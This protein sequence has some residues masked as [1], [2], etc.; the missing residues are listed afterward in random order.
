M[1][2]PTRTR[3]DPAAL[4]DPAFHA[5]GDPH[6]VWRWMRAHSPV[7]HHAP[8]ELPAFWS[9]TRHADVRDVYRDPATFSS[10][11]GVLLRPAATGEDPG[12]GLSLA[13]TDPP[14]HKQLRALV[15]AW[16][17]ERSARRMEGPIRTA[18]RSALDL[19]RDRGGCEVVH[20]I[21][22]RVS[23]HVIC[24][25]L[26]VPDADHES[27]F[28]WTDEAYAVHAPLA[29][30]PAL[31]QYFGELMYQRMQQPADDIVSALANGVPVGELL[32]EEEI[33][34][35]CE[36]LI[37]ATENGRL[38]IAGG[39][40]ALMRHPE[41]WARLRADRGLVPTAVEEILRWTSSA[42]HSMRR[43][44]RDVTIGGEQIRAGDRVVLWVPSANRDEEVFTD[45]DRFDVGRTPNR[46]LALGIGEHFCL[47]STMART[48]LRVLLTELLDAV[49]T[50]E[51]AG[52]VEPVSSIAVGGAASLPVRLVPLR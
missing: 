22:G 13:L 1:S 26:G 19:A 7:H 21:A 24:S 50:V 9:L 28:T 39:V 30:H 20:D 14:R 11:G 25:L 43:A 44:T 18:V 32:T 29:A 49:E 6:G 8:S 40:L 3:P 2:A 16:F 42:T 46:H 38:A 34:L 33:L 10:A 48:Q 23:I 41:Q 27:I 31:M 51:P 45:P 15:A 5:T 4:A 35:N 36:N 17:T 37:G 47:G 12:G 52:P